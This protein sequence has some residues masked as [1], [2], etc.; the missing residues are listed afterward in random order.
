MVHLSKFVEFNAENN[1]NI[2]Q[3]PTQK[4]K[5]AFLSRLKK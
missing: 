1:W 5:L 4:N 3:D 2:P